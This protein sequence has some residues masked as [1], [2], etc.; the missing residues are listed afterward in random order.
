VIAFFTPNESAPG[1]EG[2]SNPGEFSWHEL[3]TTNHQAAYTF[4]ASLFNWNKT[5]AMDMGEM[6]IYQMFGRGEL[7]VGGMFNKPPQMPMPMWL[8]YAMVD[9]VNATVEIV[10]ENGGHV[11]NGPME[12]PDGDLIA[13]CVDPQGAAFA[14]HSHKK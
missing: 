3:A 4:Y 6:G 10:K 2:P 12:V 5:D 11:L 9:D 13:Q 8:Y 7:P 1:H 14:I